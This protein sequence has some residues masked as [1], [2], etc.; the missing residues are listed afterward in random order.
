M[1]DTEIRQQ[2]GDEPAADGQL[3][4][5]EVLRRIDALGRIGVF[6]GLP[7]EQLRWFA[8][9]TTER[10]LA[11]G[12]VLFERGAKA[13]WMVVYLEGES[14]VI[15]DRLDDF[16][17]FLR[18][19]DPLT[20]VSGMLPYSRMT[21]FPYAI[22]A[23]M[24]T[25]VL[26]F[27]A[28][29]FPT[30][31]AGMPVLA[32]RLVNLMNDRVREATKID[33]HQDKLMALG[34]LSSGLAHELNNPAAAA[35]R[36]ADELLDA[37]KELRA[38]DLRLC[39]HDLSDEQLAFFKEFE[40]QTLARLEAAPTLGALEQ[41]DR[42]DA[43][44]AWLESHDIRD[45]W[46]LAPH[47]VE[48][49]LEAAN[50]EPLLA[51]V[52]ATAFGGVLARVAAQLRTA[53]LVQDIKVGTTRISELVG[54]IKEYSYMDQ[55]R[56]QEVDL[57]KGLDNT[58]LILKHKL[59]KKNI[60]VVKE[61]AEDLPQIMA[62]GGELNQVWTNLIVNAIEA[63]PEG[64]RLKVRTKREP[65]NVMVEI[66]DNGP[67]IPPDVRSRIFEPFFTTK[68]VG[69]GTGLGLDTSM[70]IVRNHHGDL[71]FE[72]KPGDTCFQV[73]LPLTQ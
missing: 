35:R 43:L 52:G 18:A 15:G 34:K 24:P 7:E 37:L 13:E 4:E 47:F 59:K 23:V 58:L 51:R 44:A 9:N 30:L 72:S 57:H 66:R 53:R 38:A 3:S 20:E 16:I 73:R 49:G 65:V 6:A 55:A 41:G 25:H 62:F 64:G 27:P 50:L 32:Q 40:Q 8:E 17:Y 29:L 31:L 67:G 14:Q 48:A 36:A 42:E 2:P 19:G 61:Y 60:A 22:R 68:P 1:Q 71:R 69:E 28:R 33:V 21:E 26:L 54:A 5:A 63:M 56:R 12:E 70:R 39:Q 45:G 46:S 11:S 10:H